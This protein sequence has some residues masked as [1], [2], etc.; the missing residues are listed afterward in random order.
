MLMSKIVNSRYR[1][2]STLMAVTSL[3]ELEM[4]PRHGGVYTRDLYRPQLLP[5]V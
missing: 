3:P 2:D 4:K 1:L 5:I